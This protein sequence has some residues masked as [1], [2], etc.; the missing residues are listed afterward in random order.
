[1]MRTEGLRKPTPSFFLNPERSFDNS[2]SVAVTFPDGYQDTLNLRQFFTNEK[3]KVM[4]ESNTC[5]Y[6]GHLEREPG[7]CV[8]MT[9][10]Y[11]KEDVEF[12]IASKHSVGSGL[13]KWTLNGDVEIIQH[14]ASKVSKLSKNM[15]CTQIKM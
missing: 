13:Y 6:I 9:G 5:A 8:A 11:G 12:S 15:K 2:P 3:D 1:M 14:S 10:C 7:A 4:D